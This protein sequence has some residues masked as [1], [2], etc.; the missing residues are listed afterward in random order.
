MSDAH[1]LATPEKSKGLELRNRWN[2]LCD[3]AAKQRDASKLL[4]IV[5]QINQVLH[6]REA[7]RAGTATAAIPIEQK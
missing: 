7:E 3:A 1:E 2:D 6:E 5:E 4:D